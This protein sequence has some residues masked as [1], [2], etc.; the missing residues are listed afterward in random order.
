MFSK[1]N[2]FLSKFMDEK[3]LEPSDAVIT[4][5][6]AEVESLKDTD[7]FGAYTVTSDDGSVQII[8][9][10]G[11]SG[12]MSFDNYQEWTNTTAMF[13][14]SIDEAV[15]VQ[16]NDVVKMLYLS[17]TIN[18]E[19]GE[20]A[21]KVKRMVRD[22]KGE[23]SIPNTFGM[24]KELGDI[25]YYMAQFTQVLGVQMSDVIEYNIIKLED[26]TRRDAIQGAGDER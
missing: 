5:I 19:A 11:R 17:N 23:L 8:K 1:L 12:H 25:L 15:G 9:H 22:D 20:L 3:G 4:P 13:G 16:D 7:E 6:E 26:R 14:D 2:E 21:G 18:E 10:V 24:I